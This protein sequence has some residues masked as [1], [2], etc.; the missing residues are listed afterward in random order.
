LIQQGSKLLFVMGLSGNHR[1]G[2]RGA[3]FERQTPV[4]VQEG[5]RFV[6]LR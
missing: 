2:Q 4:R 5:E 3:F 6:E 1:I